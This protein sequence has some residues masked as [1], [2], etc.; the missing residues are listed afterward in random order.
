MFNVLV[1]AAAI[2]QIL[3]GLLVYRKGRRSL[4]NILFGVISLL[5]LAWALT[6]Y[7]YTLQ[8]VSDSALTIIRIVMFFVV[9]Q[10]TAFYVFARNYPS[11][12]QL[13]KR[14]VLNRYLLFSAVVAIASLSPLVFSSVTI[15]NGQSNP[16]PGPLI[17]LFLIHAVY[18]IT[19]GF[20]S[21]FR[22]LSSSVGQERKQVQ[23]I[24]FA[25]I[26]IW[27]VVPITNFAITLAFSTTFFAKMSPVYTLLFSG[28]I[29]YAIVSQRLFDIQA[30]VARSVGYTMT[31][32]TM[33]AT[34]ISIAF[35]LPTRLFGIESVGLRV[36]ILYALL[37]LLLAFSFQNI[38]QIF[39]RISNSIF[40][41]DAYDP[42]NLLNKVNRVLA[43]TAYLNQSLPRSIE[44]LCEN[45]KVEHGAIVLRESPNKDIRIFTAHSGSDP[46]SRDIAQ[47][48]MSLVDAQRGKPIVAIDYIASANITL[49][50]A[51]VV[52]NVAVLAKL[53]LKHG[54]KNQIMGYILLG[55]KRSGNAYST[56]DLQVIEILANELVIAAENALRFEEIERFSE[57]LQRKVDDATLQLRATN[58]K[59]KELNETKD[60]FIGMA[61]H[62][63]RT[64]LTSVKGY[65]SL[66]MDGDAGKINQ[67]QYELLRQ[68]FVSSQRMVYL[69]AD[70]LNISRLKTGKFNIERTPTNLA[71]LINDEL[72]QLKETAA[73]RNLELQFVPPASFPDLP[74]DE[75][76][77][78]QVIMNFI[79]N[80]IYYTPAGGHIRVELDETEKSVELRVTD[81]GI[82][83]PASERH[84]LWTK[85][86]RAKNAQRARPDGTGLGL[87]MA[88]KVITAQGGAIVFETKEGEGSTFG[89]RFPKDLPTESGIVQTISS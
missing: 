76:K 53:G 44:L 11:S 20:R 73:S 18:S 60:D 64:P 7:L 58:K 52:H 6:N 19:V 72:A 54:D 23:F 39:D 89:F 4:T 67:Q 65:I 79:D 24:I 51:L 27:I 82:G 25:S 33:T 83:V 61:S 2:I 70:L 15:S 26:L 13:I 10:N 17:P 21:M 38:K 31:L 49:R 71:K 81:D 1:I 30:A 56:K 34:Y 78:R 62:Q 35:V 43:T 69:I 84:H 77:T 63:L 5:T 14:Q 80:A 8:P 68:A 45:L 37:A 3:V 22:T 75:T 74:L 28:I 47:E 42:Q 32:V 16:N 59:L 50:Q 12:K 88:K 57:T 55:P 87:Y 86:Y 46:L 9:L 85:F 29:A 41:Q 48:Y 36:Q 66:V 40:Y